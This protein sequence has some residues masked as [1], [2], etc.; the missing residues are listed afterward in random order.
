MHHTPGN[1]KSELKI[2]KQERKWKED[3]K[4]G[5]REKMG[6]AT[7]RNTIQYQHFLNHYVINMVRDV[8]IV[9]YHRKVD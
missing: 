2:K 3:E 4:N 5:K 1:S 9:Y 8:F 6:N 7:Y